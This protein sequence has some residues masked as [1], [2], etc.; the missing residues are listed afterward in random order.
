MSTKSRA[1]PVKKEN[2]CLHCE[3]VKG[4]L[5]APA[6]G[7]WKDIVIEL[8]KLHGE[9]CV[10]DTITEGNADLHQ[11]IYVHCKTHGVSTLRLC[12]ALD[13]KECPKCA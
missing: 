8:T 2:K 13:G 7:S 11:V 1:K 9:T 3:A 10:F 5:S 12:E 4:V 6:T